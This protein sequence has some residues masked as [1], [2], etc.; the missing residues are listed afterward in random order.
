MKLSA[1]F[2]EA[3]TAIDEA[4][5]NDPNK[6]IAGGK[7]IPK[8]LLYSERMT[9][10]LERMAPEASEELRL[11]A[12]AQH[13]E[14][15]VIP[16]EEYPMDRR[17]YK[18]WRNKLKK[19]HADRADEILWE[20]GYDE[21]SIDRVRTL[22]MKRG[23]KTDPEVQ[24][25]EDVICLVFLDYY[26]DEFAKEHTDEKLVSILQKTWVKMSE[27]GQ[28]MAQSIEMSPNAKRLL[29]KALAG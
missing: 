6:E 8:E 22:V 5:R 19:Y 21:E 9:A 10:W 28:Q 4:N 16:R 13:I 23:I 24:L 20:S 7:E 29:E 18:Q 15:W 26:F 3:I 27:E 25:L 1:R 11:A 14:R 17:G 2:D 12:R